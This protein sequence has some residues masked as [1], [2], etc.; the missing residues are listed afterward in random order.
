[1]DLRA[2]SMLN[3]GPSPDAVTFSAGGPGVAWRETGGQIVVLDLAGSVYFG[4]NGSG[5]ILWKR[6]VTDGATRA[7]LTTLLMSGADVDALRAESDVDRFLADLDG[8]TLLQ[9]DD[10]ADR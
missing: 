1:M 10:R 2:P 8:H 7:E 9:R 6:L 5:A 4:L 3:G